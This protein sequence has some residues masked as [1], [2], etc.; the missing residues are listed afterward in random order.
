MSEFEESTSIEES[1]NVE[2]FIK[3]G[4]LRP[5]L[6]RINLKV[7][8]VAKYEEREGFS[9]KTGENYRVTEVLVGDETG[10]ILLTLWNES[11]DQ[12]EV[13]GIYSLTN[14]YTSIFKGSLRLNIGRYGHLE[15]IDEEISDV[16]EENNLSNM[17]YAQ[18]ERRRPRKRRIAWQRGRLLHARSAPRQS[19]LDSG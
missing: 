4:G 8:C 6:K 1:E 18:P 2:E 13:D 7:K 17:V 15:A 19:L 16:D 5:Q 3:V 11:I 12:M 14:V 10:A 9:R